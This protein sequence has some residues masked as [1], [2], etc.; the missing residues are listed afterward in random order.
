VRRTALAAGLAAGLLAIA[1]LL[2]GCASGA[3]LP[4]DTPAPTPTETTTPL[5]DL[6]AGD[7]YDQ[8]GQGVVLV[9]DCDEAHSYEVFASL[10]LDDPAYP[11]ETLEATARDRCRTAFSAFIGIEYDASE[12]VLR[13]VAPSAA[14]WEQ[15]DREI[16]CVVTDPVDRTIGSLADALR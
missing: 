9:L 10:L 15:G 8:A 2:A 11:A 6:A 5:T 13:Y 12:L 7:C 1:A 16:L 4:T 14:T 3:P